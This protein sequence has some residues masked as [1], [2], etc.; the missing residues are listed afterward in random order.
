MHSFNVAFIHSI[1]SRYQN[2][3]HLNIISISK[4]LNNTFFGVCFVLFF[5]SMY[6]NSA[7]RQ[8]EEDCVFKGTPGGSESSFHNVKVNVD[9]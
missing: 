5:S 9:F 2:E 1:L 7:P 8:E 4:W 6:P 3:H